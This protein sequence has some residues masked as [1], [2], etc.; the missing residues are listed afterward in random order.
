MELALSLLEQTHQHQIWEHAHSFLNAQQL[1]SIKQHATVGQML[2]ILIPQPQ[3]EPQ[4]PLGL[5]TLVPQK[6]YH[7]SLFHHGI[8]PLIK[9]V[10]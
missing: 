1:I 4:H 2:A 8:Y 9:Y 5:L 3:M 6:H 7:A 10:Y